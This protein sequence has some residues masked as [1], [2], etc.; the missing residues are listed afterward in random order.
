MNHFNEVAKQWDSVEKIEM[1]KA[2]AE[3]TVAA[4]KLKRPVKMLDF[5]CGTGLFSLAMADYLETLTG[6]DT[7]SGML[8]IFNQKTKGHKH[9]KSVL[10]DLEQEDL[11]EK[12]DLIV[13]S[14]AFHHLKDPGA[15][16]VKLKGMLNDQGRI[17]IVDLV[18]EDGTFHPD[19]E[20]MG[21]RHFG[22]SEDEINQW[23]HTAGL[24]V[25]RQIINV[26]H[27]NGRE[28]PQFLAVLGM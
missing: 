5:G 8:E 3:K 22:F 20:G 16:I 9:I 10:I 28:Y 19:N 12:F 4:L 17:A 23:A 25:S 14:M 1:M 6:V 11:S 21:V 15:M 13:S 24:Q 27:K 26:V 7:S 18:K 2:L